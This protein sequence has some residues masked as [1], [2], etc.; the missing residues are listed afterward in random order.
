MDTAKTIRFRSHNARVLEAIY[1]DGLLV[2]LS[3]VGQEDGI[4]AIT[5]LLMQ[6]LSKQGDN[7]IAF[8]GRLG[9]DVHKSGNRRLI[10]P[11]GEGHA[12][13]ILFHDSV[14]PN[15]GMRVLLS[16]N[17]EEAFARFQ[18]FLE[19]SCPL[20]RLVSLAAN[21]RLER[22]IFASLKNMRAIYQADTRVGD[23][24]AYAIDTEAL[25]KDDYWLLRTEMIAALKRFY[26]ETDSCGVITRRQMIDGLE[27]MKRQEA[28]AKRK[29]EEAEAKQRQSLAIEAAKAKANAAKPRFYREYLKD[30][31]KLKSTGSQPFAKVIAKWFSPSMTWY[32]TEYDPNEGL[33]FGYVVNE[34]D[35]FCSEWGY[36]S[37]QELEQW[38]IGRKG[39]LRH[40]VDRDL[41][42]E[43]CWLDIKGELFYSERQTPKKAA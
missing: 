25:F 12:H 28:E 18:Q 38:A 40:Y 16:N 24:I 11:I 21:D 4:K 1:A 13:C 19:S 6:G 15:N 27:Q 9:I 7:W 14:L 26:S 31:P 3:I 2:Y 35:A 36:F 43:D 41:Y 34:A 23:R 20:P 33:L 22:E 39:T 8:D 37:I 29:Q 10:E 5:A 17:E 30:A 32:A 42:L